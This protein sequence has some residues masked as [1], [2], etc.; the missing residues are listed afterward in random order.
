MVKTPAPRS[1]GHC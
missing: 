1:V